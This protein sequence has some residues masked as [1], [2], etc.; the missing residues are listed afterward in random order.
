MPPK[1]RS[2]DLL[3]LTSPRRGHFRLESG[4]HTNL[5]LDLEALFVQPALVRPF[6]THLA[7]ALRPHHVAGGGGP[8]GRGAF[9]PPTPPS[10]AQHEVLFTGRRLPAPGE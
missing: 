5:W 9:P 4:H 6:V 8:P 2:A 7:R 10:A 3:S 1:G